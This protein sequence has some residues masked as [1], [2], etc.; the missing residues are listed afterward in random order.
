MCSEN[1]FSLPDLVGHKFAGALS[2]KARDGVPVRLIHDHF[3]SSDVPRG[4]WDGMR[5]AGVEVRPAT[6]RG[7]RSADLM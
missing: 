4:F 1:Y 3:G 5:D 2:E 6:P 7:Y